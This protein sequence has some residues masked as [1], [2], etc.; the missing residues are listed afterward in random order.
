MFTG[1][2]YA[3]SGAPAGGGGSSSAFGA[4]VP[5]ILMF[6]IFY[7]L[8]IRPQQK[9]A[10]DQRSW[11]SSLKKGDK[12]ITSG[13]LYGEITGITENVVTLE[14]A[15]KIRVKVSRAAIAA[16]QGAPQPSTPDVTDEK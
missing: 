5:L 2:A 3:M 8:L 1:I 9:K 4:M 7:F 13:G 16:S 15:P 10:K 6:V 12:I 14:I 11:N